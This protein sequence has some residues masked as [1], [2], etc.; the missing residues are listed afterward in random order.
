MRLFISYR[1]DDRDYATQ[2][3]FDA[4]IRRFG[5]ENVFKDT[6]RIS[7]GRDWAQPALPHDQVASAHCISAIVE[8]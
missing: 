3:I 8:R 6:D 7:P 5:A 4:L 2:T 1:H